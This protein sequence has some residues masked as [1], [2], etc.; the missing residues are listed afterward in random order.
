VFSKV[1]PDT[2]VTAVGDVRSSVYE[3]LSEE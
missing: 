3:K 2:K 1:S